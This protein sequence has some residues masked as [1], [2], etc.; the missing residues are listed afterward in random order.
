LL[1][2]QR[3]MTITHNIKIQNEKF[4]TLLD[5]TFV[6]SGQFKLFLK[7]LQGCIEMKQ[8]MTFFDG[9]SFFIHIPYHILK[10]SVISTKL[11]EN[12]WSDYVE[13]KSKIE[14]LKTRKETP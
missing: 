14:A 2:K 11:E 13:T 12:T 3:Q 6:N 1:S 10:D 7:L 4:G 8:D 5:E 9:Q